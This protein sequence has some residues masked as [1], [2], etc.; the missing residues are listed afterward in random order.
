[1]NGCLR[2]LSLGDNSIGDAGA[3]ALGEALR[4]NTVI[5]VVGLYRNEIGDSGGVVLGA[6]MR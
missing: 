1:V 2:E 6:G 4:T 5:K 3:A